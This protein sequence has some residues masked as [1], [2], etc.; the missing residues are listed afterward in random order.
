[1]DK[2]Y[3][4]DNA[5]VV[6][7]SVTNNRN[8]SVYRVSAILKES[9]NPRILQKAL[10]EIYD[11]FAVLTVK[12]RRGVFWN[13]FDTNTLKLQ[14]SEEK[15][16]PC[17][18]MSIH[19]NNGHLIKV[20]YYNSRI[21]VEV[22]HSLTDG[23]GA[24]EFL[25]SLVYYYLLYSG[26]NVQPEGLI[27]LSD[28]P[29]NPCDIED[30]F[31]AYYNNVKLPAVK[32]PTAY[33]IKGSG[34]EIYG[35]SVVHA[36]LEADSL[37]SIA[38]SYGATITT[39]LSAIMIQSIYKTRIRFDKSKK[40]V[41]LTIPINL[42][43]VF[44]SK[45]LRNFFATTNIGTTMN[46]EMDFRTLVEILTKSLRE[47][48][49]KENLEKFITRNLNFEKNSRLV[50]LFIK[51]TFIPLGFNAMGENKKTVTLSNLGS[52]CLPKCFEN[53]VSEFEFV[54][55][56]TKKCPMCVGVCSIHNRLVISVM[57]SISDK[58]I[59]REFYTSLGELLP[60]TIYSNDWGK[61]SDETGGGK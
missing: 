39:L 56:P 23:S 15:E 44:P 34:F 30:S 43:K 21:S 40:P 29:I 2:W 38:K 12:M 19:K 59:V 35:N 48:T 36:S 60:I 61:N 20:L 53:Y 5:A 17:C 14:V 58:D 22:F 25:K 37:N 49:T 7:P 13:Y 10:D 31:K 4:L 3:K 57:Q 52:I 45:T 24:I 9:I 32:E 33:H 41:M 11:L 50:P 47:K 27:R 54:N 46:E 28:N 26:K 8:T 42:R 51:R 16:Y 55:Y 6:F 1:M 18:L